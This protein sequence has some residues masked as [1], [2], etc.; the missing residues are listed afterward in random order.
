M[1]S[2]PRFITDRLARKRSS[3]R[4]TTPAGP[5]STSPGSGNGQG[6]ETPQIAAEPPKRPFRAALAWAFD[7][8]GRQDLD[9]AQALLTEHEVSWPNTAA[10]V[11]AEARKLGWQPPERTNVTPISGEAMQQGVGIGETFE[12]RV[13]WCGDIYAQLLDRRGRRRLARRAVKDNGDETWLPIAFGTIELVDKAVSYGFERTTGRIT[14]ADR[15]DVVLSIEVDGQRRGERAPIRADVAKSAME[16]SPHTWGDS[17]VIPAGIDEICRPDLRKWARAYLYAL[18][19]GDR[20]VWDDQ[21]GTEV[22]VPAYDGPV[23]PAVPT[24]G[25]VVPLNGEL[26]Y[27]PAVGEAFDA[28]GPSGHVRHRR[29]GRRRRHLADITYRPERPD[30]EDPSTLTALESWSRLI[31][32]HPQ[33][34]RGVVGALVGQVISSLLAG[35]PLDCARGHS[36]TFT[37]TV[38]DSETGKSAV[39]R[40]V[41]T[42]QTR[43]MWGEAPLSPLC[44]V[45]KG[46]GAGG[47]TPT[48]ITQRLS[49]HGGATA[50]LD[51]VGPRKRWD[52]RQKMDQHTK[53]T[54]AAGN[55]IMGGG[56]AQG[57]VNR[58]SDRVD[59]AADGDARLSGA[60]TAEDLPPRSFVSSLLDDGIAN[61]VAWLWWLADYRC[62]ELL[63]RLLQS[64][65]ETLS[66]NDGLRVVLQL[67]LEDPGVLVEGFARACDELRTRVPEL[68]AHTRVLHHYAMLAAGLWVLDRAYGRAGLMVSHFGECLPGIADEAQ[69]M[70][71][72]GLGGGSDEQSLRDPVE[73]VRFIFARRVRGIGGKPFVIDFGEGANG[74][75]AMAPDP[76]RPDDPITSDLP[77]GVYNEDAGWGI[78]TDDDGGPVHVPGR[79]AIRLRC[80]VRHRAGRRPKSGFT[81]RLVLRRQ[82]WELLCSELQRSGEAMGLA[83][84]TQANIT[85]A[86]TKA[87]VLWHGKAGGGQRPYVLDGAWLLYA[88]DERP[89]LDEGLGDD[90]AGG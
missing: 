83:T 12:L 57:A 52:D 47:A 13:S 34:A 49:D 54:M 74:D 4:Q 43:T 90:E 82:D 46:G 1:T 31:H 51:E 19:A 88:D 18:A 40:L 28:S 35:H 37:I 23:T 67:L 64:E 32:V 76:G 9:A 17:W 87:G 24:T 16:R 29:T 5:H 11:R 3:A 30:L 10:Y 15:Q 66:R 2:Q 33:P 22:T 21:A 78:G 81:Y 71:T 58:A 84:L 42:S 41:L 45:S 62:P 72:Y 48:G 59:I 77:P 20:L 70:V 14:N 39:V 89:D 85:E 69:R 25:P 44:L 7:Q 80:W 55:A 36:R 65:T 86:L 60:G 73:A 75:P 6:P 27:L 26:T 50:E 68:G 38:G 79:D 63:L 53:I 8:L 61:R 56:P